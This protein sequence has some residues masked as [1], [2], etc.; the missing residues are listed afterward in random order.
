MEVSC[1]N[2]RDEK[3]GN[4]AANNLR[5]RDIEQPILMA[6]SYQLDPGL[7]THRQSPVLVTMVL[8]Y[9]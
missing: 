5:D 1:G 7:K 8:L 9:P 2:A 4:L 3:L 6:C